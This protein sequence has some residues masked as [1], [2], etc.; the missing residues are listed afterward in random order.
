MPRTVSTSTHLGYENSPSMRTVLPHALGIDS[1]WTTELEIELLVKA[2]LNEKNVVR[3][4][5]ITNGLQI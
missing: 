4:D 1:P 2:L 5:A 3:N